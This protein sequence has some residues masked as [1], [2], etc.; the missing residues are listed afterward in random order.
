MLDQLVPGR[1]H[2]QAAEGRGDSLATTST[3]STWS[4]SRRSRT[5]TRRGTSCRPAPPSRTSRPRS[6]SSGRTPTPTARRLPAGRYLQHSNKFTIYGKAIQVVGAGP[7]Y[8]RF[9]TPQ[10]QENTNAG[11][12]V[13]SSGQRVD[14]QEPRRSS[15][16][17]RRVRTARAR[18]GASCKD[19]DNLT[20]D[21]TWVE[22]TVCSYWGVSVAG[23]K[24]HQQPDPQH[25]RR[26]HQHDQRQHRATWS[27]MS[28]PAATAT[29]RS[30]SS[31]P[32]TA[33]ARWATTTT[34]SRTCRP[35]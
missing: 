31:P 5:R 9:V 34:C 35:R 29:T 6:T 19:V 30:R 21:N 28:R 4:R 11:F 12:D 33:A 14:V 26:R 8:T 10:D 16:T 23:L 27:A 3:S 1:Q 32:S 25:L 15:A 24:Y 18:S 2:D 22:H 13:Q 17:T 7:W 20:I